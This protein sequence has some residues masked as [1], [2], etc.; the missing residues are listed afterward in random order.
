MLFIS[1]EKLYISNQATIPFC[2]PKA[3]LRKVNPTS[4][5]LF[6]AGIFLD[7]FSYLISTGVVL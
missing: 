6:S 4:F 5:S 3:Q 1:G 2:L 7:V